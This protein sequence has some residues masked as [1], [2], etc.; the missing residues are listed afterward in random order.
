[1]KGEVFN[2]VNVKLL[3]NNSLISPRMV[4]IIISSR[5]W[6]LNVLG[7]CNH[8]LL[9]ILNLVFVLSL[10]HCKR[11]GVNHAFGLG[12]H[13]ALFLDFCHGVLRTF[14]LLLHH[15]LQNLLICNGS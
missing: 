14:M 1:M 3:T 10:D 4:D 8:F 12:G 5:Y 2:K 6:Q 15:F 9:A 13:H 7:D 11:I